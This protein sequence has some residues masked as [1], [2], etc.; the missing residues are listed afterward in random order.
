MLNAQ[1]LH[2]ADE[3]EEYPEALDHLKWCQDWLVAHGMDSTWEAIVPDAGEPELFVDLDTAQQHEQF[4]RMWPLVKQ[5][6]KDFDYRVTFSKSGAVHIIVKTNTYFGF[7][8][9]VA[10]QS[11]LGSD[12]LRELLHL[13]SYE[14]GEANPVVLIERIRRLALPEKCTDLIT[15]EF[16]LPD[17][18][19]C[20]ICPYPC[21][22][23]GGFG[24][25][26]EYQRQFC[27]NERCPNYV[28]F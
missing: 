2:M 3:A 17:F 5:Q 22:T 16:D 11:I 1:V 26:V 28:P 9:R 27:T 15:A 8:Q 10:L 21:R 23:A 19:R 13:N 6:Y 18:Q 4:L 20:L 24:C 12:P 7:T 14:K 25:S